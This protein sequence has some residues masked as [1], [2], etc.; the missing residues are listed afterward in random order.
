MTTLTSIGVRGTL[1]SAVMVSSALVPL[2]SC[3]TVALNPFRQ[4][5][6]PDR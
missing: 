2:S 5:R 1:A 4:D 6:V 3:V